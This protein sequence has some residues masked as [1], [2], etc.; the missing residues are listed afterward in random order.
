MKHILIFCY[1]DDRDSVINTEINDVAVLGRTDDDGFLKHIGHKCEAFVATDDNEERKAI[2]EMLNVRRK[3]M[4]VN[5]THQNSILS[6]SL[7]M[8]HGNFINAGVIMGPDIQIGNH[9]IL[10]TGVILEY[11][12]TLGNFV[13]I[14]AGTI[15]NSE[16]KIE[17]EVFIGSGVSIVS[18]VTIGKRARIGAGSIVVSNVE[19]GDTEG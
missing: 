13:Q 14:G 18:G 8:G 2:V 17:D 12:V 1:L 6:T 3:V 5:A 19:E 10:N 16:T 9:C 7:Q 4:P 11:G 15:I